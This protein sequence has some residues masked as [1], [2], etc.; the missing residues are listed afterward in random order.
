MRVSRPTVFTST[1]PLLLLII[2]ITWT[3]IAPFKE[4]KDALQ[5]GTHNNNDKTKTEVIEDCFSKK[6][7]ELVFSLYVKC[8]ATNL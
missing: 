4:S 6:S 3:Y 5:R 1:V 8:L 7:I 2:I